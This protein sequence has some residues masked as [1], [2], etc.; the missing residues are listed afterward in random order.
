M[1][2]LEQGAKL[3]RLARSSVKS[4]FSGEKVNLEEYREFSKKQGVFVTLTKDSE[5]RGCIGFPEP[6]HQLYRAV[7]E[8]ARSAAFEDPRFPAVEEDE[9][10]NISF[11]ISVLTVPEPVETKK[12]EDYIDK[13]E[14]GRD[15][16]IIRGSYGAG[17]LLPQV[18]VEWSWSAEEF[19]KHLCIKA[20][21][22]QNEW[23]NPDN[24]IY[25]FQAQI[26]SEKEPD[27]E[28][29]EKEL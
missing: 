26:F 7:F 13:I 27:G 20:G 11:E 4:N 16:L 10:E 22:G 29:V 8:A 23:K 19:L 5:L 18:P 12:P 17:L 14:I 25:S 15:G 28:V 3:V 2:S 24:K 6:T 21:L 1:L 9:L